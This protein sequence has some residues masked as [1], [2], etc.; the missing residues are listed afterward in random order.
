MNGHMMKGTR[1][2]SV[3]CGCVLLITACEHPPVDTVQRGYRGTG[4]EGVF[5]P[6]I[7]ED[8]V[9]ANIPPEPSP[10]A[11][12]DG[13]KASQIYQNVQILGDL[14]IA[15]F[16]RL[17]GAMTSWVSPEQGCNY[18]HVP[19][20]FAS[21]DI[22]TKK[23]ARVMLAMTQRTNEGWQAHVGNTGVTCY[24]CHRG[25]PVPTYV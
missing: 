16:T 23:V 25:N 24:T 21:D 2:A 20:N 7:I 10:P 1:L 15:Q 5:N 6:R 3:I 8:K 12:P 4:M 13:P 22:Y 17:M 14:S 18:C 19:G 9:A 11:S